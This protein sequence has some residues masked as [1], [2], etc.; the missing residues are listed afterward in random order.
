MTLPAMPFSAAELEKLAQHVSEV[1]NHAEPV[2][3]AGMGAAAQ[4]TKSPGD[5]ATAID[6]KLERLLGAGLTERTGFAVAGEE[7]GG[8]DIHAG[9]PVWLIDPVDGTANFMHS[10]PL[11]GMNCAL[12]AG[13]ASVL[14]AT[15]LPALDQRYLAI[16]GGWVRCNG[17][18]LALRAP[19][20]L[21]D[22][23]I[24]VGNPQTHSDRFPKRFRRTLIERLLDR[25]FRVRLLGSCALELAWVAGGPLGATVQFSVHPW[26]L[27]SGICLVSAAGGSSTTLDGRPFTLRERSLLSAVPDVAD[28]LAE[29][30]SSLGDPA[31]YADA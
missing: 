24:G 13:G 4:I 10:L 15:W 29:L 21:E 28:E 27:A 6:L 17:N 19:A 26:D 20:K 12:I 1:L 9:E 5:Y 23:T 3:L 14:G 25:A 8:A 16:A 30:V 31:G 18:V 2:F 22:V 7:F 11:S